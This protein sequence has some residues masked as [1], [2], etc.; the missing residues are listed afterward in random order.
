MASPQPAPGAQAGSPQILGA[1]RQHIEF[2]Q[3][4]QNADGSVD[5]LRLASLLEG[6]A[7]EIVGF[8]PVHEQIQQ[9]Y[10]LPGKGF[11]GASGA[12]L[13]D[14]LIVEQR[15]SH[16]V[17]EMQGVAADPQGGWLIRF[18][19]SLLHSLSPA[20]AGPVREFRHPVRRVLRQAARR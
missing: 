15:Y 10:R 12:V 5:R 16:A 6:P 18:N 2:Q 8:D 3:I 11:A 17:R 20:R 4:V 7:D 13:E 9:R 19:L 1:H 14:D